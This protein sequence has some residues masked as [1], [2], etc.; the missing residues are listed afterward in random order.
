MSPTVQVLLI[1][2]NPGDAR[3]IAEMLARACHAGPHFQLAWAPSLADG[4]ARLNRDGADVVLLDLGLPES[5]GVETV[6]RL[7]ALTPKVPALVV[8]SGSIDEAVALEALRV[9]AQDY[10]VKGHV[11]APLLARSIRYALGRA[12][13]ELAIREANARLEQRVLERTVELARAVDALRTE[14]RERERAE[15][16]N[17]CKSRFLATM[18]HDLRTPLNGILGFARLLLSEPGLNQSQR[19][20]LGAIE[21]SGEH[22]MVLIGDLLDLAKIEAGKLELSLAEC[23]VATL[24]R[25]VTEMISA[26]MSHK[27]GLSLAVDIAH[28]LPRVVCVDERRLRQILV[29]LLDNAIKFSEH[30]T[31][32]LRARCDG[33]T[34]LRFEVEDTGRPLEADQI[35]RLFRPFE[36]VGD[37]RQRSQGTGLGL[38][39]CREL[40]A[41]MGGDI[42]AQAGRLAGNLFSFDILNG[43]PVRDGH[44]TGDDPVDGGQVLPFVI[45]SHGTRSAILQAFDA[46]GADLGAAPGRSSP[47]SRA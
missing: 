34:H 29:N 14:A 43:D 9:G 18:S 38:T 42:R 27:P 41:L 16:A 20:S 30:G 15:R 39:I 2:D 36:Q 22:L 45:S 47:R 31:L 35:A 13:A 44:A 26:K 4:L 32:I 46:P 37:A 33:P 11:D 40:V 6:T 7:F 17:K 23:E 21:R 28:D 3:L 12:E 25:D 24:M 8:M 19:I 10:L 5:S 1:E